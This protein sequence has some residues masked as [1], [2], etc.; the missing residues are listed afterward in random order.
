MPPAYL[1]IAAQ[2][3]ER[4]ADGTYRP[5]SRLPGIRQLAVEHQVSEIVIRQVMR[6]LVQEGLIR[7]VPGSGHY[8]R[9]RRPVRRIALDRYRREATHQPGD[10]PAT[11]FTEDRGIGWSE[12]RLDKRFEVEAADERLARLFEVEPGTPVLARHFVF[13]AQDEPS[14]LSRSCVLQSDVE[15]TPV[16]DPANEPWPGGT[17][18]QLASIGLSVTRVEESVRGRL[19]T[20]DEAS[21]LAMEPSMPVLA[22][23]R[24]MFSGFR[25]VEVAADIVMPAEG[26]SLD[27]GVDL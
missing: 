15:G 14:Q 1:R 25:V 21:T 16:A 9:R 8:V 4:V 5:D 19:P 2:I 12:Y 11:S 20:A 10:R 17:P 22:I 26:V 24:R 13:Y 3:R 6:L 18:A 7:A 23:T 27:Y